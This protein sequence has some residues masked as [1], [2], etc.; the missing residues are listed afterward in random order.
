M[1]VFLMSKIFLKFDVN[2]LVDVYVNVNSRRFCK[3]DFILLSR[4]SLA[5]H[6]AAHHRP[7]SQRI[8]TKY[9]MGV[10]GYINGLKRPYW[11]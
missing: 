10:N 3:G 7:R 1:Q 6:G 8:K 5:K 9:K 4:H 11:V 2:G